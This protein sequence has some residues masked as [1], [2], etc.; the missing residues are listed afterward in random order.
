MSDGARPAAY[1]LE[2]LTK[3]FPG[4]VAV[5]RVDLEVCEGEIHGII[6]KNGAGKSA[7]VGMIAGVIEPT[8]GTIWIGGVPREVWLVVAVIAG[9]LMLLFLYRQVVLGRVR[10]NFPQSRRDAKS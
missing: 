6:G 10:E 4:V 1:R 8:E 5:D 9:A 3:I 2:G 7:L